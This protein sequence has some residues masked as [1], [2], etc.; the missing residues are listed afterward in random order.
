VHH[1]LENGT[2]I[3]RQFQETP[4]TLPEF[5]ASLCDGISKI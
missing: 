5:S 1:T 2:L 4:E 3:F